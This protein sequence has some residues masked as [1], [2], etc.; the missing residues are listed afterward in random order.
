LW[1]RE[2][3]LEKRGKTCWVKGGYTYINFGN[4]VRTGPFSKNHKIFRI[5]ASGWAA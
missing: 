4:S 3:E 1:G 2:T 5:D